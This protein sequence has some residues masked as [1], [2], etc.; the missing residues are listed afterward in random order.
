[1]YLCGVIKTLNTMKVQIEK[2]PEVFNTS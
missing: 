1:L 2:V